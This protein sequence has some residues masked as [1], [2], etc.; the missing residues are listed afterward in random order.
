M[1]IF[2]RGFLPGD[3]LFERTAALTN[4]GP[5]LPGLIAAV[6]PRLNAFLGEVV[7]VVRPAFGGKVTYASLP[8]EQ[9]DWTRFDYVAS[10][11]YRAAHNAA[12]FR[13]EVR[14][15]RRH[16]LPVVVTEFGCC[17]FR[18]AADQGARGWM[19]VDRDTW[20]LDGAYERDE[21]EQA[22]Y[23]REVVQVFDE[24]GVDSAFW[25]TYAGYQFPHHPD[26]HE[27]LDLASYG[28]VR[29]EPDGAWHPKSVFHTL[30]ST[31]ATMGLS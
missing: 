7:E 15:L 27:D 24:E 14:A 17:T 10:D 30:S 18:G 29:L 8:F 28:V 6:P 4:P 21:E 25:F 1:S 2:A 13:E 31:Y 26:P 22:A 9:V 3:D 12:R 5:E 19:I 20:S 23:F 16:G 11:A